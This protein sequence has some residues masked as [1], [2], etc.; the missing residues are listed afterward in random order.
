MKR[1]NLGQGKSWP[2][3][4]GVKNLDYLDQKILIQLPNNIVIHSF[5]KN[6][7]LNR[8]MD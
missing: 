7:L 3:N 6:E 8:R 4:N 5:S 2:G 1:M